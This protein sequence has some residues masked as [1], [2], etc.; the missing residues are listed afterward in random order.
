MAMTREKMDEILAAV[1]KNNDK[2]DRCPA[3]FHEFT[4]IPPD[5]KSQRA[6]KHCGGQLD[7]GDAWWYEKGVKH[8]RAHQQERDADP[9]LAGPGQQLGANGNAPKPRPG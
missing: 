4:I 2:L 8:G 5:R 7:L 3:P 1:K 6:C 9:G